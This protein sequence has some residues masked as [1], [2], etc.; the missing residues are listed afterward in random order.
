M[1]A[2][3]RDDPGIDCMQRQKGSPFRL[4]T[5]ITRMILFFKVDMHGST[6]M[7]VCTCM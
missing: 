3:F 5:T 1:F 4:N 6:Y 2:A 7:Y